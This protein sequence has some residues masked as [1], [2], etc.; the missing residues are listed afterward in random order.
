MIF[1]FTYLY[2]IT[3]TVFFLN[4]NDDNSLNQNILIYLN[5]V[6]TMYN[7]IFNDIV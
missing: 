6:G 4:N 1:F 7:T 3:E 5:N 2:N